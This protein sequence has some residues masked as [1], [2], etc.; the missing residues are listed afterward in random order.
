MCGVPWHVAR[1]TW[2]VLQS[3]M[4][5]PPEKRDT[6]RIE[7]LGDLRGEVMVYQPMSVREIGR[8]GAQVELGFPLQLDS[9]HDCRLTLGDRSLVVKGRV[10]HCRISDVDHEQVRYRAG[11]EF[12]DLNP[13]AEAA[14]G[15]FIDAV[16]SGRAG[17][18]S[19]SASPS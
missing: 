19:D 13:H 3:P 14:I 5:F 18:P 15:E 9:L 7:I 8:R 1:G 4:P 2:R 6:E 17:R 10:V 12:V 16:I 11:I